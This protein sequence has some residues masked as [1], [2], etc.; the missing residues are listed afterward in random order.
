MRILRRLPFLAWLVLV[1]MA[2]WGALSLA[3]LLS[4]VAVAAL[5]LTV[6][7]HAG[8]GPAG[9]V[10]PLH[11]LRFFLYFQYK[12]LEANF[13]VAWEVI[14]PNN[15]GINEGIVAVPVTGA[16]DAVITILANA[17]SLTPGTLTLEV[18]RDP[19]ILYVHVLHLRDIESVRQDVYR[20]ETLVLRAFADE[21]TIEAARNLVPR[22]EASSAATAALDIGEDDR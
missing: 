14:T 11:A 17:I 4:G 3:N 13:V 15:E 12:L 9:T 8:P 7:P 10:R 18:S 1:W 21:A 20:L 6:F 2:L 19:A 16:S 22:S 5:L